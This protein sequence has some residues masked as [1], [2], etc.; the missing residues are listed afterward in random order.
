[1]KNNIIKSALL[2]GLILAAVGRAEAQVVESSGDLVLNFEINDATGAGN[3]INYEYDLGQATQFT[4]TAS[5]T[6]NNLELDLQNDY[7]TTATGTSPA[8]LYQTR[9]DL[10]WSVDGSTS[11]VGATDTLYTT[12]PDN[13]LSFIAQSQNTQAPAAQKMVAEDN[14]LNGLPSAP[15]NKQATNVSTSANDSYSYEENKDGTYTIPYSFRYFD[16]QGEGTGAIE[17]GVSPTSPETSDL[18][19][20]VTGSGTSVDLGT[21]TLGPTGTFTFE[22]INASATPEPST[23]ALMFVGLG[24]C[25]A[26][27]RFRNRLFNA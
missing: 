7:G 6:F 19:V 8:I 21:F 16:P 10:V 2:A 4:T 11:P 26:L 14:S 15:F 25:A 13:Q 5:I 20:L 27:A 17:N 3:T 22:G 18:Y 9:T 24:F 1:M 12:S 23:Y